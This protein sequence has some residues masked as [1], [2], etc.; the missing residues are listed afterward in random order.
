MVAVTTSV[1]CAGGE[2]GKV[3]CAAFGYAFSGAETADAAVVD[4]GVPF[5]FQDKF[6]L[7][8]FCGN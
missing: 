2:D 6:L 3:T 5:C 4:C 8:V 7:A 1:C